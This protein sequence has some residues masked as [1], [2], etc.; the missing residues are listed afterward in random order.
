MILD[1]MML[2][3][4]SETTM[5]SN[6]PTLIVALA[7]YNGAKHLKTQLDSILEQTFTDFQIYIRDDGSTDN[8]LEIIRDYVR[9]SGQIHLIEDNLGNL[10]PPYSF[11]AILNQCPSAKYYAFAD[12]DDIW[13]PDKLMR[14]V[15]YLDSVN[16]K[17]DIGLYVSSY[18]YK[19]EFGEYIRRFPVQHDLS[20]NKNIYYSIGSGFTFVFTEKLMKLALPNRLNQ[21]ELHDR[22]FARVAACFGD[23]LYDEEITAAHIR[24]EEAVTAGDAN[25]ISLFINWL[26]TEFFGDGMKNEKLYLR[27]FLHQYYYALDTSSR[28]KLCLFATNRVTLKR[29]LIKIFYPHRLRTRLG[30]ELVLRLAFLLRII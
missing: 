12:Q 6:K 21:N 26:K 28:A 4:E 7:T 1:L 16:L 25:N 9:K 20:L 24:H 17:D 27:Q 5:K 29:Y 3:D 19:T 30:G 18:E 10:K 15:N 22:R 23:I 2:F 13:Y 11:Y 8:T 14:A